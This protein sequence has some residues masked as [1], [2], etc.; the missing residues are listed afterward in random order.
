MDSIDGSELFINC[1]FLGKVV[2]FKCSL[3]M[4]KK[5]DSRLYNVND[6]TLYV[7]VLKHCTS[8]VI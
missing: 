4:S 1:I 8:I 3:A 5:N 7:Y 6:H 2:L